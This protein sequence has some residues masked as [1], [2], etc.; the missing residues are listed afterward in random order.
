MYVLTQFWEEG[1]SRMCVC[2]RESVCVRE[3]MRILYTYACVSVSAPRSD[4]ASSKNLGLGL[5]N[6]GLSKIA[7]TIYNLKIL[8]CARTTA[9]TARAFPFCNCL[10]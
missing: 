7:F 6:I 9:K 5:S 1:V 8:M 10:P 2:A 3:C 4:I